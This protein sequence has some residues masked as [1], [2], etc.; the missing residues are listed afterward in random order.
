MKLVSS[1]PV[2]IQQNHPLENGL[3][4]GKVLK[5]LEKYYISAKNWEIVY[6]V[7]QL[8]KSIGKLDLFTLLA[9]KDV[10]NKV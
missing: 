4:K 7:D 6:S 2:D 9:S 3:K 5:P 8:Y 10:T 1:V